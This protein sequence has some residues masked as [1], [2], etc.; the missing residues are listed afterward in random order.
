MFLAKMPST[1]WALLLSVIWTR[2]CHKSNH[3]SWD[4]NDKF[5]LECGRMSCSPI[6]ATRRGQCL[7]CCVSR[8]VTRSRLSL[9]WTPRDVGLFPGLRWQ[10]LPSSYREK[11]K[12]KKTKTWNYGNRFNLLCKVSQNLV[13]WKQKNTMLTLNNKNEV[14]TALNTAK[15][16][17][18]MYLS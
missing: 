13:S 8:S 16:T 5:R 1:I 2:C 11:K 10:T 4:T 7:S 14:E 17:M 15:Q 3:V 6:T 9:F 18:K 12:K